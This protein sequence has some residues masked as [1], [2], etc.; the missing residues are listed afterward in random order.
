MTRLHS[1]SHRSLTGV[2]L[3]VV[4]IASACGSTVDDGT[5]KLLTAPAITRPAAESGAAESASADGESNDVFASN[6]QQHGQT[7]DEFIAASPDGEAVNP[8][9]QTGRP[10]YEPILWDALVPPGEST[11]DVFARF[12][13][14]LMEVEYGSPE[15]TALYEE[16]AAEFGTGEEVNGEM[17]G[18]KIRLAGFVAPLT[19]DD[20]IVTE[21]LLVPNFGACIH[22]PPPPPNQTIMVTV[23]RADGL[24]PKESWGAVWVEGTLS[25]DAT[26]TSLAAASYTIT[27]AKS[28]VYEY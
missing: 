10:G 20:E 18:Q 26:T 12:E 6:G 15:A 21:F 2:F 8:A 7:L 11:E 28:G 1:R 24:T 27:D 22:V 4:M 3:L 14:R 17:D 5:G 9:L 19:Y 25:I 23:D 13:K 16:M